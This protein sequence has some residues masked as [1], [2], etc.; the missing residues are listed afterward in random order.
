T[1]EDSQRHPSTPIGTVA[2]HASAN[3]KSRA[4][5]ASRGCRREEARLPLRIWQAQQILGEDEVQSAARVRDR[6]LQTECD[7]FRVAIGRLL[8]R[9]KVDVR[10]QGEGGTDAPHPRRTLPDAE[11]APTAQVP[12]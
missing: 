4:T 8:R 11:V 7:Q 12:I 9:P 10:Q 3:R 6:R 5:T 2:E 1:C